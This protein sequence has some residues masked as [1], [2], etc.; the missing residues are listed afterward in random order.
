MSR[1]RLRGAGLGMLWS[2]ALSQPQAHPLR[3]TALLI[4][5]LL[6]VAG[7]EA[8]DHEAC[9]H[10]AGS[11]PTEPVVE[12]TPTPRPEGGGS[13][14][15]LNQDEV[16]KEAASPSQ[17]NGEEDPSNQDELA[18]G[19]AP[20]THE[21]KAPI[22]PLASQDEVI[23]VVE[24][25][26]EESDGTASEEVAVLLQDEGVD[27][28]AVAGQE[29]TFNQEKA[30]GPEDTVEETKHF[31]EV[32]IAEEAPFSHPDETIEEVAAPGPEVAAEEAASP[33]TNTEA[34][35]DEEE[36]ADHDA[37]ITFEF[38]EDITVRC[39]NKVIAKQHRHRDARV[40]CC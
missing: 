10:A 23:E 33:T 21:E 4:V 6:S 30:P 39:G 18:E 11:A 19:D 12:V 31:V 32:E 37:L 28:V 2:R 38:T 25:I 13:E 34:E 3:L 22:E 14:E 17:V 9:D 27:E 36:E 20:P 5:V 26:Q 1:A 7:D 24:L 29:K 16:T 15:P 40:Y 8:C 35:Q